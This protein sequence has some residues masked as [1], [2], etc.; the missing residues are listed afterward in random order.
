MAP[1]YPFPMRVL[2]L[3]HP[4]L[5]IRDLD[6]TRAFYEGCLGMVHES[7]GEGRHALR[8]GAQKL[9]LHLLERP[10]DA[11]VRHAT[12]GSADLCFLAEGPL[13]AWM[14]R[15]ANHGVAIITGPITRTGATGPIRS[16]Y[17]YD[18]DE[19]LIELSVPLG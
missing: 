4:V 13:E 18:P 2:G 12:P 11:N 6:H 8:F 3:D 7:F 15:L 9:N 5:T 17:C 1:S 14:A 10:V 16:I 19:N